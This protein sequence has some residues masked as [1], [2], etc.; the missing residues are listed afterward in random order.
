MNKIQ[1]LSLLIEIARAAE[2]N[3]EL[4]LSLVPERHKELAREI[5]N[6]DTDSVC[7]RFIRS[8]AQC[9]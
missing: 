2:E 4:L 8:M 9:Q 3:V 7:A 1:Q 5:R 6:V